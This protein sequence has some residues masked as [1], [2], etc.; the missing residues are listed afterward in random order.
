M[1]NGSKYRGVNDLCKQAGQSG[2]Q[3]FKPGIKEQA[4]E[5]VMTHT[6]LWSLWTGLV[7]GHRV[8]AGR[9]HLEN[10]IEEGS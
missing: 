9:R 2:E 5:M 1:T 8:K 4:G 6:Q 7:R 10:R 3:S